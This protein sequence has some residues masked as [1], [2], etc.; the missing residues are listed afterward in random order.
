[1]NSIGIATA[2]DE[3]DWHRDFEVA[4][5]DEL[6]WHRD[7]EVDAVDGATR[8]HAQRVRKRAGKKRS[9]LIFHHYGTR[10]QSRI[11]D[12]TEY[13]IHAIIW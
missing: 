5:V 11:H 10:R 13:E 9:I 7:F 8:A 3:L 4:A 12:L 2:V 1:M 6:D